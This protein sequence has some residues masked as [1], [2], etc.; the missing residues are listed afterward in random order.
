VAKE[1]ENCGGALVSNCKLRDVI[2]EPI[3]KKP[4]DAVAIGVQTGEW[5]GVVDSFRTPGCVDI[6]TAGIF[7]LCRIGNRHLNPKG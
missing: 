7:A 3:Y 6:E 1:W 5:L 2:I 4:F